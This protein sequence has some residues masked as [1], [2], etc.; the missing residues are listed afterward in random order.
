MAEF[1]LVVRA[2][3]IADGLGGAP[4]VADIGINGQLEFVYSDETASGRLIGAQIKAGASY[5][6]NPTERGWKFYPEAKHRTYWELYP[7]LASKRARV[8]W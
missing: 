6:R 2:A 1:D 4:Y 5:F 3:R 7:F 8:L